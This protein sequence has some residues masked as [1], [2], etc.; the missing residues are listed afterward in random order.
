MTIIYGDGTV[1]TRYNG[2]NERL[3]YRVVERGEGYV[4]IRI[5]GGLEDGQNEHLRF[6]DN[7]KGYWIHSFAAPNIEERFDKV[8][9]E[10]DGAANQSQPVRA[11]TNEASAAAGSAR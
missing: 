2:Q 8:V 5:K 1:E 6:V 4:V 3:G 7:N 10:P 9:I 11:G